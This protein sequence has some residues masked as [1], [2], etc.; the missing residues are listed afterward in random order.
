[1]YGGDEQE[2]PYAGL[3]TIFDE[4]GKFFYVFNI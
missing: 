2:G 3:S 4:P 1:M